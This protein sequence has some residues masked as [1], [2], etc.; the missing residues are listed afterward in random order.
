MADIKEWTLMFYFASDNPLAPGIVSQLKA[1]KQA[2]FHPEANVVAQ[3][4]PQPEGTP[5]HIFDVNLI[6]KLKNPNKSQIGFCGCTPDDPFVSNLLEDKLWR[7]QKDRNEQSVT[8][9]LRAV[10]ARDHKIFYNPPTPPPTTKVATPP[11]VAG[12][13]RHPG[14]KRFNGRPVELNP[15][16]SL[17]AFLTFCRNSYPARHY[18]LFILGHGVVVGNDIF[19]FDENAD[20]QSLSLEQLGVVLSEFR[21]GIGVDAEFELVS[22]HSCSVSSLEVAYELGGAADGSGGTA[23]YMLASQGPAFVGSWPYRQIL[24]RVLNN[25]D[26]LKELEAM[27]ND[28]EARENIKNLLR[29]IFS[30]CFF[31][32][33][34]FLLAGYSFDLSLCSLNKVREIKDPLVALAD[35]L[36]AGLEDSLVRDFILLAHWESQS[37]WQ[38]SYTDLYDFCLC[39]GRKCLAFE[40]KFGS[41][42]ETALGDTYTALREIITACDRVRCQLE[43]ERPGGHEKIIVTAEFAGPTY[44]YSHGLSVFFP[45]SERLSDRPLLDDY[46][47]YKFNETGWLKFLLSYFEKTRRES[48]KTEM[49]KA[50]AEAFAPKQ[51]DTQLLVEDLASLVFNGEGL[52]SSE[53]SLAPAGKINPEDRT[54]GECGCQTIK[55]YPLDVR[56]RRFREQNAPSGNG[57]DKSVPVSQPRSILPFLP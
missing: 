12:N 38:E 45:W 10:L 13:P 52:L 1:I 33:T 53:N 39:L 41:D 15:K 30:D 49:L 36:I 29:G 28:G 40:G 2:G 25:V 4:D 18:M 19:L 54:G 46:E 35:A 8:S 56:A 3:F 5:T 47:C 22:F 31:N 34:D 21:T 26:A 50:P 32:S 48:Q 9:Q 11:P 57:P 55:N 51:N 6:N 43:K 27:P 23:N 24:M 7:D 16:E 42:V 44:Q 37:H 20:T 17:E 14:L